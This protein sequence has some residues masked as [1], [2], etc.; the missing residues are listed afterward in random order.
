MILLGLIWLFQLAF[1]PLHKCPSSPLNIHKF[2]LQPIFHIISKALCG[3]WCLNHISLYT[4]LTSAIFLRFNAT[5]TGL[6]KIY[7]KFCLFW[8]NL[9]FVMIWKSAMLFFDAYWESFRVNIITSA[10]HANEANRIVQALCNR[11]IREYIGK[12]N[13]THDHWSKTYLFH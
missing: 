11:F 9:F 10:N 5:E 2:T 13:R 1:G 4:T 8:L 7:L 3:R 12:Y 6:I